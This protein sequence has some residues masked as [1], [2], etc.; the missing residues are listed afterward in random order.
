MVLRML[1]FCADATAS[2]SGRAVEAGSGRIRFVFL[3]PVL[4]PLFG[5]R[6]LRYISLLSPGD[7]RGSFGWR[8]L[9][10]RLD[11]RSF[12]LFP[13]NF[14]MAIRS[15]SSSSSAPDCNALSI[16]S[17]TSLSRL[18]TMDFLSPPSPSKSSSSTVSPLSLGGF[19]TTLSFDS[20]PSDSYNDSTSSSSSSSSSI[21]MNIR[22]CLRISFPSFVA[23]SITDNTITVNILPPNTKETGPCATNNP[24]WINRITQTNTQTTN[25]I[26]TSP[27]NGTHNDE[28]I[29]TQSGSTLL[30]TP[31]GPNIT[32][33]LKHTVS[34]SNAYVGYVLTSTERRGILSDTA[35]KS[36]PKRLSK[37]FAATRADANSIKLHLNFP[38]FSV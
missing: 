13:S 8:I 9:S 19:D 26:T 25:S 20:S 31:L 28:S 4:L 12:L 17:N 37:N 21:N 36:S 29:T 5:T 33:S 2:C 27:M 18:S 15:S 10:F 1:G 7:T 38:G 3:I 11:L 16:Q 24:N 14:A 32:P 30:L 22:S 23:H 34:L 6:D 35:S